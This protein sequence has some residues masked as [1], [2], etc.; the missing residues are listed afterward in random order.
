[1]E[2][3]FILL[4]I[5]I[6][7]VSCMT[8]TPPRIIDSSR[9]HWQLYDDE[10]ETYEEPKP[11]PMTVMY[12]REGVEFARFEPPE[13]T[14][15]GAWL[16]PDTSIRV[17]EH[18]MEKRHAIF[19]H[20]LHLGD[21]IPISWLLH[22]IASLAT[23]LFVIH[24]PNNPELY[25]VSVYDL[26]EYLAQRL[27]SFNLPMFI[28][29]YA[30]DSHGLMP[31]EFTLLFRRARNI[32]L[33]HAPMAAFVWSAP[34]HTATPQNPFYPGHTAV[35]WVALP[36]LATWNAQT[37]FKNILEQFETFYNSF[38]EHKP[39]MILPL[40]VSHFTRGDYTYRLTQ[41]ASEIIRVYEALRNFPRLGLI[42][43]ADALTLAHAHS[44]DFSVSVEAELVDAYRQA[45]S[46]A[47]F[48]PSLVRTTEETM[49][50]VRSAF[51]GYYFD[52]TIYLSPQTLEN[53]LKIPPP[54][55][56]TK[57]NGSYFIEAGR[58]SGKKIFACQDRQV[59]FIDN[60]P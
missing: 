19:A 57:I 11:I 58:I 15:V 1:M 3:F 47:Q 21:D 50:F 10:P 46:C 39:I 54:R 45:V 27:G 31:A 59:I 56:K 48:L 38:S 7:F 17:F 12:R 49:R 2:K 23:P 14:Y 55:Q 28:A 53:E 13:G 42:I 52:G 20:E 36:L 26:I 44:E 6:L 34:S 37:D 35:D 4:M 18:V 40:G 51:N 5:L 8:D 32:F 9:S 30:D 60:M 24:P 25:D 22:C 43:Y 16:A 33:H 41:A 29:F